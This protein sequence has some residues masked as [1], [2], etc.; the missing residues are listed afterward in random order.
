MIGKLMD[1][2]NKN[3]NSNL[4]KLISV[5]SEQID[6][7]NETFNRIDEWRDEEKA[8]G[9]E[10]DRIGYSVRQSRGQVNDDIY[11]ILI[12]SK[13]ARDMSSGDINTIINVLALSIDTDPSEIQIEELWNDPDEPEPASIRVVRIPIARLNEVE[14]TGNQFGRL[15]ESTLASGVSVKQIDLSGTFEFGSVELET[16]SEAGFSNIDQEVGGFFGSVYQPV[17][18][19]DIPL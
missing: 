19:R 15:V 17:N 9:K 16:D 1:A 2:Y 8:E 4:A 12:R 5:V 13:R 11:R 3:P 6:N 10:L 14:L 18:D 7:L